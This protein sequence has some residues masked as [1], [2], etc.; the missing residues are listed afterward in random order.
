MKKSL[1]ALATFSTLAACAVAPTPQTAEEMRAA[2]PV[3]GKV[4]TQNVSRNYGSVV[5][6][7]RAGASRCL[8]RT[9]EDVITTPSTLTMA[10]TQ[11]LRATYKTT[12]R[13][14]GGGTEMATYVRRGNGGTVMGV[15]QEGIMYVVDAQ[16]VA[17]GTQLKMYGGKNGFGPLNAAVLQWAKGGAIRCPELP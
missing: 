1:L 14:R 16:P 17:G 11:V 10:T 3:Y 8:N 12:F 13:S 9:V 4:T 7:L 5:A 6:S 15:K 2:A